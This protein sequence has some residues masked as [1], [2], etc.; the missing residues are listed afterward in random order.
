MAV[1][2]TLGDL[3][4]SLIKRDLG[5]KDMGHLLPRHG[6]PTHRLDLLLPAAAVS[7]LL[8]AVLVARLDPAQSPAP[9]R[10]T[11]RRSSRPP[12][13]HGGHT[14]AAA[15]RRPPPPGRRGRN[16]LVGECQEGAPAPRPRSHDRG[17]PGS[18]STDSTIAVP[19]STRSC[20]DA[21]TRSVGPDD[22]VADRHHQVVAVL[23]ADQLAHHLVQ[24]V[25]RGDPRRAARTG[26]TRS[27]TS[28]W[29]TTSASAASP[30][31]PARGGPKGHDEQPQQVPSRAVPAPRPP[32]RRRPT[33]SAAA[34][35][36]Q[37][38]SAATAVHAP[39]TLRSASSG[40]ESS[41][42]LSSSRECGTYRGS[43]TAT[44]PGTSRTSAARRTGTDSCSGGAPGRATSSGAGSTRG[45]RRPVGHWS[46]TTAET[47]AGRKGA[48]RA[49]RRGAAGR[50]APPAGVGQPGGVDDEQH[51]VAPSREE[52]LRRD[53]HLLR[54]RQVHEAGSASDGGR[55]R[56]RPARPATRG[57]DEVEEDVGRA[58]CDPARVT[59][60]ELDR[61]ASGYRTFVEE[62][63]VSSPRYAR[64][65]AGSGRGTATSCGSSPRLPGRQA[66]AESVLRRPP[67]PA[68]RAPRTARSSGDSW[69]RGTPSGC[70][71]HVARATQTN[72]PPDA[73]ACCRPSA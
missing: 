19:P 15:S 61:I 58:P 49:G 39:A 63:A 35:C 16:R 68:R 12:R 72:E 46:A 32:P 22:D 31:G 47:A 53:V 42:R 1:T 65:A 4:E 71:D 2:A 57:L 73:P 40:S 59:D 30:S 62:A 52:R 28:R 6:G 23:P 34:R 67:V 9:G 55:A 50:P 64:L 13:S 69:R 37:P 26:P 36:A 43:R 60:D 7:Y 11:S 44:P 18:V 20:P 29:S 51:Q 66:S 25:G 38:A 14:S 5:I 41:S 70:G 3:G 54:R 17:T 24:E 33:R 45:G 48:G 8:L 21:T 56:R 27:C 10:T